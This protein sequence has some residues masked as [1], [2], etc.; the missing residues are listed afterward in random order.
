MTNLNELCMRL[1]SSL[2]P[3]PWSKHIPQLKRAK[4]RLQ[5]EIDT[6][7]LPLPEYLNETM[8][9]CECCRQYDP[10]GRYMMH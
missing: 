1:L 6:I 3:C 5:S 9:L 4:E 8:E 2:F 10:V 7:E